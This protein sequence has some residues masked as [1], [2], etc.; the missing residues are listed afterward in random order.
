VK[1]K[2]TDSGARKREKEEPSRERMKGVHGIALKPK[3]PWRPF[4]DV[5]A[6]DGA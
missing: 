5:R 1:A 6:P 4:H 2:S 3:R